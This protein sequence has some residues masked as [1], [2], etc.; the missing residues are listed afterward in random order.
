VGDHLKRAVLERFVE[1]E[2]PSEEARRIERHL[3][4]CSDCREMADQVSLLTKLQILDSWLHP[5]Y[6]D[7]FERAA[8]G[9][10]ERLESLLIESRSTEDLFAELL[11]ETV[12]VRRFKIRN[13][14]RFHSLKL[15]QLLQ[16]RS[17]E[18]WFLDPAAA[19]ELA[20]LAVVV[21]QY[22]DF[23][24]YGSGLVEDSRALSL[25]YLG[26]A[27]RI[28]SDLW[29]ADQALRQAWI[30][31]F[32]AGEDPSTETELLDLT[33]SLRNVQ[34][35]YDEAARLSDRVIANHREGQNRRL[36][37]AALI[38]KACV[39]GHSGRYAEA[40]L[41]VRAG[42]ARIDANQSPQLLLSGIHNLVWLLCRSGSP[43]KAR[44]LLA[45]NRILFDELGEGN[46]LLMRM[47]RLEGEVVGSLG[48]YSQA[49]ALFLNARDRY[50]EC[51]FGTDV[52]TISFDLAEIYTRAHQRRKA[53]N[54]LSEI[55]P[56]GE[57][58][59]LRQDVF[60]ARLLYNQ[61]S[62]S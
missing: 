30:H 14:E 23:G 28:T 20:D 19:L 45:T 22:L 55:I 21:A 4:I 6:D 29:R 31:H 50:L 27:F 33:C 32:E 61:V 51:G 53:K 5:G 13:E 17:R 48:L 62:R 11:R 26:N 47:P 34:G 41:L 56:M 3:A 2:L 46:A 58:L 54:L 43:E 49:E 18:N 59:G 7:A 9:A 52:L 1:G 16:K 44:D 35:R 57:A 25:A 15:C 40:T 42:L 24:R 8:V 37:G 38:H 10:A 60:L 12:Q 36:E 39:L